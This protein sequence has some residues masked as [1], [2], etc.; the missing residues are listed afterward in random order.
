[1]RVGKLAMGVGV[2]A[3]LLGAGATALAASTPKGDKILSSLG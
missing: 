3:C 1:M 2:S